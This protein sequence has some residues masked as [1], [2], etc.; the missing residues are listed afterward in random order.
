MFKSPKEQFR[1]PK[2][3]TSPK[4]AES[5]PR[6]IILRPS[7]KWQEWNGHRPEMLP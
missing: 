5:V 2:S 6:R 1:T 7:C 4:R 3:G